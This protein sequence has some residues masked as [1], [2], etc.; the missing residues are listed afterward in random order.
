MASYITPYVLKYKASNFFLS[1]IVLI[2]TKIIEK[3]NNSYDIKLYW[4]WYEMYFHNLH[5]FDVIDINMVKV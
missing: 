2:V 3:K 5:F 1:K 4:I